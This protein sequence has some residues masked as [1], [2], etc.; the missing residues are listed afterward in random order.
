MGDSSSSA[1]SNVSKLTI[2]GKLSV[3]LSGSSLIFLVTEAKSNST[4]EVN[5]RVGFISIG[6]SLLFV[7]LLVGKLVSL[8]GS[9]LK[10]QAKS[11]SN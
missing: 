10:V 6:F 9:V 8:T 1:V 4:L 2:K 5:L 11:S 3:L 7:S